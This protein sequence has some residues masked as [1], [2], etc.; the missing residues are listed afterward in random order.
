MVDTRS[1][2]CG[3]GDVAIDGATSDPGVA[4][5]Y[6]WRGMADGAIIP[7]VGAS[8][9]RNS[10]SK[11]LPILATLTSRSSVMSSSAIDSAIC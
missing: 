11:S 7:T 4:D 10:M 2:N 6:V 1:N 9:M 5:S 8:V 3:G